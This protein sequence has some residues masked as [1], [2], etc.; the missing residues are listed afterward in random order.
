MT[1][2]HAV[3]CVLARHIF[4][5]SETC[6]RYSPLLNNESQQIADLLV[7]LT[8]GTEDLTDWAIFSVSALRARPSALSQT[9]LPYQLR[10]GSEPVPLVFQTL[11]TGQV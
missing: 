5:V 11:E 1:A 8:A 7:G 6:Y 4:D 10:T 3:S 9:R 2:R